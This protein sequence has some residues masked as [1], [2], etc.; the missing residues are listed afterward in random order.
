MLGPQFTR[1]TDP[2]YQTNR[3]ENRMRPCIGGRWTMGDVWAIT[4]IDLFLDLH[5]LATRRG[6]CRDKSA[7]LLPVDAGMSFQCE[8]L[9]WD[10]DPK[11]LKKH[12][13]FL[14]R[15]WMTF[16]LAGGSMRAMPTCAALSA[17]T[18]L[19]PS[20]HMNE[21]RPAARCDL[22]TYSFWSGETRANTCTVGA[23]WLSCRA[24]WY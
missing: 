5:P 14:A 3:H 19:V 23:G 12:S 1:K 10:P 24:C 18:S 22:S 17:P 4:A 16:S 8:I 2:K 21:M 20:P 13:A 6:W 15:T 7:S 11:P 9:V